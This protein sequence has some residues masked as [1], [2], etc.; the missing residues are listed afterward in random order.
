MKPIGLLELFVWVAGVLLLA[1]W[2]IAHAAGTAG[3]RRELDRFRAIRSDAA[4]SS[5]TRATDQPD[6][7]LWSPVRKRAWR[8][9]QG[10]R[11]GPPLAVLRIR[12]LDLEVPLLDGTDEWT[13]NRAAGHIEGTAYP[14]GDGNIGIAAHRDGFFRGLKDVVPG[15]AVEI[16]MPERTVTFGAFELVGRYSHVDVVDAAID[17]GIFDRTTVG[18]NWW[19]TRRWKVGFD[20]GYINLDRRGLDGV[21]HAFHTRLQRVY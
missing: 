21:T 3:A 2:S 5:G 8:E 20:Y 10:R 9:T 14:G 7:R 13:L 6:Q 15:D 11:V 17:G 4:R 12:R 1:A 16:E 18:I 19:A